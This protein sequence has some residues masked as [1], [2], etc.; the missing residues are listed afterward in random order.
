MTC[1]NCNSQFPDSVKF[2]RKCGTPLAQ[3]TPRPP[4]QNNYTQPRPVMQAPQVHMPQVNL[5]INKKSASGKIVPMIIASVLLVAAI[6]CGIIF[7]PPLLDEKGKGGE[8]GGDGEGGGG[9][10]TSLAVV[11]EN[12]SGTSDINKY[13]IKS[14]VLEKDGDKDVVLVT[15]VYTRLDGHDES[16]MSATKGY[17]DYAFQNSVN[18]TRAYLSKELEK[19]YNFDGELY[20]NDIKA[21]GT[22]EVVLG[23][24]L[25]DK[26]SDIFVEIEDRYDDYVVSKTFKIK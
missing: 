6:V 5:Q 24:E 4:V 19:K 1:P 18:L 20:R 21:G 11:T 3:A 14:A 7:I 12:V 26:S 25:Y 8:N 9:K 13:E 22:V 15:V 17:C 2:C 16:L 23:F 10:G